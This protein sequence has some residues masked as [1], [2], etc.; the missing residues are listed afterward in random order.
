M[1][2]CTSKYKGEQKSTPLFSHVPLYL[3]HTQ[4]ALYTLRE[5]LPLPPVNPGRINSKTHTETLVDSEP[6]K[7]AIKINHTRIKSINMS[8]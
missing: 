7:M 6:M 3:G 8:R 5:G 4:K 1:A 2:R